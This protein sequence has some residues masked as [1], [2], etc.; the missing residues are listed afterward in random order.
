[1]NE[2]MD[3]WVAGWMD[4]WMNGWIGVST[5]HIHPSFPSSESLPSPVDSAFP[6]YQASLQGARDTLPNGGIDGVWPLPQWS[7]RMC[8]FGIC[9]SF[10]QRNVASIV[11]STRVYG[12]VTG[13]IKS[14]NDD[15]DKCGWEPRTYLLQ[16]SPSFGNG[17]AS[18]SMHTVSYDM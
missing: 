17:T 3:G 9:S 16:Q 15:W 10:G 7:K 5:I 18:I 14:Y 12:E 4:E 2:C 13:L 6:A 8:D 1:M 11:G